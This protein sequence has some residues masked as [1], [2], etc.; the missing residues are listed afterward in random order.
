MSTSGLEIPPEFQDQL[1]FR[2]NEDER[3]DT[4]ILQSL[5]TYRPVTSEKN[6]WAFWHSGAASMPAWQQ[7]NVIDWIRLL[8]PSWTVRVLDNVPGSPSN[9]LQFL[10][11]KSLPETFVRGTMDGTHRGQYAAD[12]L[13]GACLYYYGGVFMDVGAILIRHLDRV[14][15]DQLEDP[16]S[17]FEVAVPWM[18]GITVVNHFVAS[19]KGNPFIKRWYV[20]LVVF[21]YVITQGSFMTN[22][23]IGT[24]YSFT[25]GKIEQIVKAS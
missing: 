21:V 5:S 18:Y 12:M 2:K 13:R 14:C 8:G 10:P 23:D 24:T 11:E 25:F 6:V 9:A 22:F 17:P 19:R 7:R 3:T 4:E 1:T 15:W 16:N 20:A